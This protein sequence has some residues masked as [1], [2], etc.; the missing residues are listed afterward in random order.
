M[1]TSFPITVSASV[2]SANFNKINAQLIALKQAGLKWLHYD[3]M[4]GNFVSN[5]TF[6]HKILSDLSQAH[7]FFYDC[8]LMVINPDK[9]II[10]YS[11]AGA[12]C[13]TVHFEAL[14]FDEVIPT[15]NFIRDRKCKV[16]ISIKPETKL[17]LIY[18]YLEFVDLL[19]IMSVEPGLGGQKFIP[20]ALKKIA[21]AKA[22]REKMPTL[23]YVI[24]VDGGINETTAPLCIEAGADILV[25]GSY[26][27]NA[28]NYTIALNKLTNK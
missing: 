18:E 11:R 5:I 8:H 2:L 9:Q 7:D 28:S 3:V 26:L 25:S 22:Y 1:K 15:L 17:E 27:F 23:D 6:G 14:Y 24:S 16:G 19:L 21:K 10:K 4:D 13:I 12:N 20:K